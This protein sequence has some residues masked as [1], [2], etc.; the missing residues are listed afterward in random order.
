MASWGTMSHC[1]LVLIVL[2][3]FQDALGKSRLGLKRYK[4]ELG[5]K[6]DSTNSNADSQAGV[7]SRVNSK[8]GAATATDTKTESQ[9]FTNTKVNTR[10][11]TSSNARSGA[12][13]AAKVKTYAH[14]NTETRVNTE[15]ESPHPPT[16]TPMPNRPSNPDSLPPGPYGA[17]NNGSCCNCS[18]NKCPPTIIKV[19]CPKCPCPC[20]P[21]CPCDCPCLKPKTTPRPTRPIPPTICL[22][23]C[24]PFPGPCMTPP[25]NP[26]PMPMCMNPPCFDMLPPQMTYPMCPM[27]CP[28]P[29]CPCPLFKRSETLSA[30][31]KTINKEIKKKSRK[32]KTL[33][34]QKRV[35]AAGPPPDSQ[36]EPLQF[37]HAA[38]AADNEICSKI[39]KE[40]LLKNGTAADAIV[41]THCC[42]EI[43]NSH[44]TGLGGGGFMV[45][46]EKKTGKAKAYDF[47]ES[48]VAA[49]TDTGNK[50][51]G[52]TIL[53]PG[54]LKGLHKVWEDFG[55]LPWKDLWKPCI[56]LANKGFP[57]HTALNNAIQA[58][59]DYILHNA[60]LR[61]L[62]VRNNKVLKLGDILKRP[63]L[64]ETYQRI[65]D[66]GSSDIFYYGDIA[67]QIAKDV[68]NAGGSMTKKDL[69]DYQLHVKKPLNT[70]LKG[71]IMLSTP[72]P[73]SGALISLAL[74]IMEH[75]NWTA[76]DQYKNKP[77]LYH[78]IVEAMK[79]A[80]APYSFLSDP[81]FAGQ[82]K[83]DQ[84][85][86]YMLND[87]VARRMFK[88][89]DGV[90]HTVDYY[91]PFN[92]KKHPKKSGTSHIS[93][94]DRYG[95]AVGGTTSIN[96]YFGSKLLSQ[97]LGFIYNNELAD[98]SE[99]WPDVYNLNSDKK[100]PGK[101]P[102]SKSSPI[103][104]LDKHYSAVGVFG[105]AGGF[106]IPSCLIQ[107][108]ANWLFF[109]NNIKIAVSK[110]RVHCQLF[111]P[112]VVYEP[113]FPAEIIP[114]LESYSHAYVTNST[115]D[116]SGQL[117][118]IMGVV[119]A[120][121]RLPNGK[122]NAESDYRKGGKPAG[123]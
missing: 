7:A 49:Y 3:S 29:P 85:T 50:T 48:L 123:F 2:L 20:P 103:I 28:T 61:S 52:D 53:V 59:K 55:K 72:P 97:K 51:Q 104:F 15:Q 109:H 77:L 13:A 68:Q 96:A 27:N 1:F 86:D 76:N 88:R 9:T 91:A 73:G 34:A 74:K 40:I 46:Y 64:A 118:A 102:M 95:N 71:L 39:G 78:R 63:T 8:T 120:V 116:V 44:S 32:Q 45:Y 119:Q 92:K 65:A 121:V 11:A 57:I 99:F 22:P 90:S 42:V 87:E 84:Y 26:Q 94:I 30:V 101:R 82:N 25:C 113:T 69:E 114:G 117:N 21:P 79:F 62:Y 98:F 80:Y 107:T 16:T 67:D 105:A 54:V 75:F 5:K 35:H 93:I 23:P 58:K 41:S 81:A 115:Y 37:D 106:F 38:V 111:P 33:N 56:D 60:A 89:I 6:R 108:I 19:Y 43:V 12:N 31:N 112:T 47:R 100:I 66:N 83:T 122:L 10:I 17:G 24:V 70:T 4:S 36:E 14:A 110:P 18:G